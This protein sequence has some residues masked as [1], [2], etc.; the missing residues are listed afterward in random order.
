MGFSHF[1]SATLQGLKAVPIDVEVDTSGGLP[2]FL[3]VGLPDAAVT[4]SR[5]RVRSALKNSDFPFP[6]GVI[7]VN[8][9]PADIKKQGPIY[10]LPIAL[11]VID[12]QDPLPPN[13]PA[14]HSLVVGELSLEG[15]VRPIRGILPFAIL[16]KSLPGKTIILPAG[17]VA[18]AEA[19]DDL[20]IIGV[21]HL[22]D[23]TNLNLLSPTTNPKTPSFQNTPPSF[24]IDFSDIRGHAHGKRALTIAAAGGHNLLMIGPPGSGKTLLAQSIQSIL[25]PMLAEEILEVTAIHSIAGLTNQTNPL[26][27]LR[28]FRS[29]H[30]SASAASLVG[31]GA[32]ARPGEISLAHHGVLYLDELPE[33]SKHSLESLRQPLEDGKISIAR[34]GG[35]NHYPAQFSLIASMNPCPCGFALGGS[36]SCS[37]S[38][39]ELKNYKNR[40]S[41]P[42]LDRIDLVVEIPRL[43]AGDLL[44][45]PVNESNS[46][47]ARQAVTLAR[48]IQFNRNNGKLNRDLHSKELLDQISQNEPACQILKR[49]VDS[50][51]LSARA[52]TRI[53]KLARTIADLDGAVTLSKDHLAEAL[54][55]RGRS[56]DSFYRI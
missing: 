13:H 17:N 49:S 30:H 23:I 18:E 29:P 47:T 26:I 16:A 1:Q 42:L 3:M 24:G 41:G 51:N 37:C 21:T 4:E 15:D 32:Q 43:I 10:D 46:S 39:R 22:R 28:P 19:I 53:L 35:T 27:T 52:V 2:K 11:G 34:A 44:T 55:F 12:S 54:Q 33:F 50:L 9:A 7:T 6:R 31:G 36:R 45:P 48:E 40:L 56:L 38:D 5:E 20:N 25:P 8:L 14:R